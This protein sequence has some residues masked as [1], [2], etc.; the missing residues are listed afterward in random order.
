VAGENAPQRGYNSTRCNAASFDVHSQ[1][2][3]RFSR[4]TNALYVVSQR[5]SDYSVSLTITKFDRELEI[6]P[7]S[8]DV[9]I[10]Y[11]TVTIHYLT[12]INIP[13][14]RLLFM[15]VCVRHTDF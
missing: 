11:F 12:I 5:S 7:V 6:F 15:Q 8:D 10:Q 3:L 13:N 4:L 14:S 2:F 9:I 1:Q